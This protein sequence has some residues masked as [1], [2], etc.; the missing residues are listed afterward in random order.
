MG[1]P[2]GG[3]EASRGSQNS[4]GS[5]SNGR[6][7]PAPGWGR[8]LSPTPP[9]PSP[10]PLRRFQSIARKRVPTVGSLAVRMP[11]ISAGGGLAVAAVAKYGG[12]DFL[13]IGTEQTIP[14]E[15]E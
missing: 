12:T 4:T 13:G 3:V 15:V 14:L 10:G 8:S 11:A 5:I 1:E 6:V 9:R 7:G 2:V